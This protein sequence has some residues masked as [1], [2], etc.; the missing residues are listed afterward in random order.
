MNLIKVFVGICG[1]I[2]IGL[3]SYDLWHE[4]ERGPSEAAAPSAPFPPGP[5]TRPPATELPS[6]PGDP[7][8]AGQQALRQSE[9]EQQKAELLAKAKR[10]A[11]AAR[12][13]VITVSEAEVINLAGLRS[14]SD[15]DI[16]AGRSD[17]HPDLLP[18]VRAAA[19][20]AY[21]A[22][23]GPNACTY[24]QQDPTAVANMRTE[25]QLV[26]SGN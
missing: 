19:T 16:A 13:R 23:A 15:A 7:Y 26:T 17:Y 24:W 2:S 25:A 1:L 20:E 10:A 6:G 21:Q 12:C 3:V 5:S 4:P 22:A 8:A 9:Y 11:W 14:I 18:A